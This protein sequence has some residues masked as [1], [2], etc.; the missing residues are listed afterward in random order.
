MCICDT[1]ARNARCR[2]RGAGQSQ[3]GGRGNGGKIPAR[4]QKPEAMYRSHRRPC[5]LFPSS[6][7][8]FRPACRPVIVFA[9][10]RGR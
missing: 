6:H 4:E 10:R 5:S 1:R 9:T 3:K 7:P 8:C 2:D